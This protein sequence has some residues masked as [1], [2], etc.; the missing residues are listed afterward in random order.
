MGEWERKSNFAESEKEKVSAYHPYTY[1][2]ASCRT[3]KTTPMGRFG[4]MSSILCAISSGT[5]WG[6][7][8]KLS[9]EATA[10]L[11]K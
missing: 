9:N 5:N 11:A 2:P 4:E 8:E 1:T 10:I 3:G 6:R 7:R